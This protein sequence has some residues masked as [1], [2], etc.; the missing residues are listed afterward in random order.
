MNKNAKMNVFE[1]KSVDIFQK[2]IYNYYIY[3][4]RGIAYE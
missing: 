3:F 1:C 2:K 4:T